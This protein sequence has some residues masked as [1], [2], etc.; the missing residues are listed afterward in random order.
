MDHLLLNQLAGNIGWKDKQLRHLGCNANMAALLNFKHADQIVGLSDA[1][2]FYPDAAVELY[3][4]H[5]QLALSGNIVQQ[6]H[7]YQDAYHFITKKP[8]LNNEQQVEGV[9]YHCQP[10]TDAQFVA[11]LAQADKKYHAGK[12]SYEVAPTENRFHLSRRELQCMLHLL[13]GKTSKEIANALQ[14]SKRTIDFYLD[15]IKNK[16]GCQ[17]KAELIVAAIEA[18]YL[19]YI[20]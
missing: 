5:D 7:L 13:R 6:V 15:N 14:L 2:L 17:N 11:K 10:L 20:P 1:D 4:Q 12:V 19:N 9:I 16:F 18:G 3:Y 8:L